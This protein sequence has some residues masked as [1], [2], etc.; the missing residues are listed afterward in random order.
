M[1][2]MAAQSTIGILGA[3]EIGR[4]VADKA[5]R[6]G[7]EVLIGNSRGPETLEAVVEQLGP[8]VHAVTAGEAAQP[9]LVFLA[10]PFSAVPDLTSLTDWSGKIV[11]DTTNQFA[12]ANPWRGRYDVG[13]LTGSEWVAQRLPG[14][15]IVKAFNSL[16]AAFIAADPQHEEGRQVVFYA[17]DDAEAK[18]AV[19]GLLDEFGF[20][21]LDLG[22]LREGGRLM[23]LDG[24]LS[25]KHLLLMDVG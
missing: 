11:V 17:G 24:A 10:V 8:K 16:F 3:G 9:D 5:V 19:A 4:A 13:D 7:H 21:A 25:A 1:G 12:A 18:A 2:S 14:A 22:G 6:H 15:R 20:A 23:Q